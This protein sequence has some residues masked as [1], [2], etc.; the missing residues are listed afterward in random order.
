MHVTLTKILILCMLAYL[1][2]AGNNYITFKIKIDD[3]YRDVQNLCTRWNA[4]EDRAA[5]QFEMRS[6]EV[7]V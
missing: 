5:I 4:K 2:Y 3:A 7:C 6:D 1:I